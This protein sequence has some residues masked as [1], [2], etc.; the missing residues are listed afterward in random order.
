M[1]CSLLTHKDK[2]TFSNSETLESLIVSPYA[3]RHFELAN[4]SKL[5]KKVQWA[6]RIIGTIQSIAIIGL[7]A[8]LIE[9]IV[10]FV[11]SYF[12]K[13]TPVISPIKIVSSNPKPRAIPEP[14]PINLLD[15]CDNDSINSIS[16]FLDVRDAGNLASASKKISSTHIWK[17]QAKKFKIAIPKGENVK[18]FAKKAILAKNLFDFFIHVP[19]LKDKVEEIRKKTDL[20]IFQQAEE[21]REWLKSGNDTV[22]KIYNI[23][24][25]DKE[26]RSIPPEIE[27]FK[28]LHGF[29]LTNCKVSKIPTSLK[30]LILLHSLNFSRNHLEKF[31]KEI[32]KLKNLRL[33]TLNSNKIKKIPKDIVRM[34]NLDYLMLDDNQIT[35]IPKEI[36]ELQCLQHLYLRN[37]QIKEVPKEIGNC[38]FMNQILLDNNLIE[39]LPE[40]I[41]ELIFLNTLSVS[42]NLLK[43]LPKVF[44]DLDLRSLKIDHNPLEE[45]PTFIR[46]NVVVNLDKNQVE[47]FSKE[48][49]KLRFRNKIT[50]TTPADFAMPTPNESEP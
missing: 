1:N 49:S 47:I 8:S 24:I 2:Y 29:E 10:A 45:F 23:T 31:P 46:P 9:R 34:R 12:K 33:L 11:Y 3:I 36:E 22:T 37:N 48:I 41:S 32:L 4:D 30:N 18:E 39:Q 38:E 15:A 28:I 25:N 44:R 19:E 13:D 21:F 16:Q 43:K 20:T 35:K 14:K 26:I 50:T 27:H 7:L 17:G 42:Y 5:S 6:H 40:E